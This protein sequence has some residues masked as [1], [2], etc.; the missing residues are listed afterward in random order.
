MLIKARATG[1]KL[2]RNFNHAITRLMRPLR[3]WGAVSAL[4]GI[5]GVTVILGG[6]DPATTHKITSTIFDGVPS[7][8]SAEQYCREYHE[9]ATKE[10]LEAAEKKKLAALKAGESEH[11]PYKEKK[12]S[13]CHNK[14]TESGFVAPRDELCLTCH[15]GFLKGAFMHGPAAVGSCLSCHDPHYSKYPSLLK[16]PKGE[17]CFVC[18]QEKRLAG[19]MHS[20]VTDRGLVCTDCHN[21][22]AGNV[23]FFLE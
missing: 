1:S 20:L 14:D 15:K 8:P 7:M 22:H 23:R 10:E 2:L 11:P 9:R 12:C 5:A 16:K 17:V 18:H 3:R 13:N 6:C 19:K 21:P 4:L